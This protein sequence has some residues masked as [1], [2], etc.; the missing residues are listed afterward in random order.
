[1]SIYVALKLIWCMVMQLK[2]ELRFISRPR[3]RYSPK[4]RFSYLRYRGYLQIGQKPTLQTMRDYKRRY[5]E[6]IGPSSRPENIPD[7]PK[8]LHR[9]GIVVFDPSV[10]IFQIGDGKSVTTPIVDRLGY[11]NKH[12][13]IITIVDDP[14]EVERV[15]PSRIHTYRSNGCH[16]VGRSSSV[17]THFDNVTGLLFPIVSP[18]VCSSTCT[19]FIFNVHVKIC[20][21]YTCTSKILLESLLQD[22]IH[23][24]SWRTEDGR[25]SSGGK[26][27]VQDEVMHWK[28]SG[29]TLNISEREEG[30]PFRWSNACREDAFWVIHFPR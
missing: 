9:K 27:L 21:K 19:P 28:T 7:V 22:Q 17:S 26:L 29:V 14:Y 13:Q 1:M 24:H 20:C 10:T 6:I 2:E 5:L 11:E 12:S 23:W 15:R 18:C 3:G 16:H 25:S 8:N 30:D 4:H